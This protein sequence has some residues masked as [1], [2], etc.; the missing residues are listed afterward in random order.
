MTT[1]L[2]APFTSLRT[3]GYTLIRSFLDLDEIELLRQDFEDSPLEV[4]ANYSVRRVSEK[5]L[6]QLDAK[7]AAVNKIV[8]EEASVDVDLL[9]DGVYF[10]TFSEKSTLTSV[11][12]GAQAFPWHQ[13]HENYWLWHDTWNYLNY[14]IPV[15]KPVLEKSNLTVVPFDRLEQRVPELYR[16]MLRRGATRVI[17]SGSRWVVKD[18]DRG[19]KLGTLHFDLAEIE[20]TPQLAPGDLLLMR[21]D[22]IHRTQDSSTKRIA[23]SFRYVN[24]KTPVRR[25]YITRGGFVKAIM[26]T[27]ARYLFEPALD[28]LDHAGKDE[29][30]AGELDAYLKELRRK[31][32]QGEAAANPSRIG[33]LA[34]VVKDKLFGGNLSS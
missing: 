34:R 30:P 20:D 4:N 8:R 23:A 17:G 31:R 13:D 24:S 16:K 9:N 18:D 25:S 14:Y 12:P 22:L 32:L 19:G 6:N 28:C 29:L 15:V 11:R 3:Q 1:S 33:F 10:A 7:L 26:T 27:N 21:G 2:A 5:V